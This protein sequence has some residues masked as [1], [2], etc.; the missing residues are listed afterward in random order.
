MENN[1]AKKKPTRFSKR[2]SGGER[3]TEG[4]RKRRRE[5]DGDDIDQERKSKSRMTDFDWD[6][7]QERL[8]KQRKEISDDTRKTVDGINRRLDITDE[9][10]NKL[11][12][13]SQAEFKQI[14]ERVAAL[15]GGSAVAPA[16]SAAKQPNMSPGG[17][18][19]KQYWFSRR[20]SRMF[21]I[22][23]ETEDQLWASLQDFVLRKLKVPR[24]EIDDKNIVDV[25][26]I[27]KGRG[28]QAESELL[29][30]FADVETRDRVASYA[31][32]LSSFVD[33]AG[34]PTAGLRLD[35]PTHLSGVFR[36]LMQYGYALKKKH[37]AEMKRNVRFDDIEQ[38]LCM[39]V[40]FPGEKEWVTVDYGM[41][42]T[43]KRARASRSIGGFKDNR[44]DTVL[45]E[46]D[47]EEASHQPDQQQQQ[48]QQH[49]QQATNG[50]ERAWKKNK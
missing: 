41:A 47:Q 5:E 50:R 27:R 39:D 45:D 37:G 15:E 32:N 40:C 38:T 34:K 24:Q 21:P 31:R 28:G 4:D 49:R 11:K 42:L 2:L 20:C 8:D 18:N 23:G 3:A 29:V 26:R 6:K 10:L 25:R 33:I 30:V 14:R 16:T 17:Q 46:D 19:S 7:L 22:V 13:D 12:D 1:E 9:K 43:D 44:F 36:A 35:I 48:Q